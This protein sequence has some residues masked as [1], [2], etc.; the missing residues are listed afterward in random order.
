MYVVKRREEK[1]KKD[2][3]HDT[4]SKLLNT[5]RYDWE[6]QLYP[7][8]IQGG[9]S[10]VVISLVQFNLILVKILGFVRNYHER[11]RT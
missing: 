4:H 11:I 8:Q 10:R 1:M 3:F 7:G 5:F 9:V 2:T 6:K